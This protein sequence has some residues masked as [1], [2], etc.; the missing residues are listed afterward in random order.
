MKFEFIRSYKFVFRINGEAYEASRISGLGLGY[1][2][3]ERGCTYN[4]VTIESFMRK[5]ENGNVVTLFDAFKK[6]FSSEN[7][8]VE[9]FPIKTID[10]KGVCKKEDFS[11]LLENCEMIKYFVSDFDV[12]MVDCIRENIEILP[13]KLVFRK[14]K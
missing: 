12:S 13:G 6:Y 4:A 7:F 11:F 3:E 5:D 14:K 1:S 9:I 10:E 2:L 8:D